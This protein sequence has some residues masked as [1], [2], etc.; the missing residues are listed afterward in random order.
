MS[1]LFFLSV[2]PYICHVLSVCFSLTIFLTCYQSLYLSLSF[3]FFLPVFLKYLKGPATVLVG[4]KQDFHYYGKL[5]WVTFVSYL[6]IL[7][8]RWLG[9][10]WVT[11]IGESL[12]YFLVHKIELHW[13][14]FDSWFLWFLLLYNCYVL[15]I[16]LS[17]S[18]RTKVKRR[19]KKKQHKVVVAKTIHTKKEK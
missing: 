12:F 18:W 9:R 7:G 15:A 2:C 13:F 6:S 3:Y 5:R 19:K 11:K 17:F 14:S 1:S 8:R 4:K 16:F 10:S